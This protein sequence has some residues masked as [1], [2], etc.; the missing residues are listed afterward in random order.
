MNFSRLFDH[1]AW[2]DQQALMAMASLDPQG[3]HH[4][5]AVRLYAHLAGAAHTWCTRIAGR[6]TEHPVWPSLSLDEATALAQA[7]VAGL[8]AAAAHGDL[9]RVVEYRNSAGQAFRNTVSDILTQVVLH[10]SYHRGQLALLAR[11]G[12]GTPAVTDYIFY[13]RT[14]S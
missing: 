5:E 7:S 14:L 2:A 9:D 6:P 11:Q 4:A 10:G 8:R 13:V 3:T 1:L 12:G